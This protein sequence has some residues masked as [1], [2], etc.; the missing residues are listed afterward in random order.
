MNVLITRRV[1]WDK[2]KG[3]CST[4]LPACEKGR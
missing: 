3:A 2:V 4:L 1:P